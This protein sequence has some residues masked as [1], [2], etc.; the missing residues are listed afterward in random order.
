MA[1]SIDHVVWDTLLHGD[2]HQTATVEIQAVHSAFRILELVVSCIERHL[3]RLWMLFR[4]IPLLLPPPHE[5]FDFRFWGLCI[6]IKVGDARILKLRTD[7]AEQS[8]PVFTWSIVRIR[9]NHNSNLFVT[10]LYEFGQ[11]HLAKGAYKALLG[12]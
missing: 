5:S 12:L 11:L 9:I 6:G 3:H 8:N 7:I 2:L 4:G 1:K 10:L